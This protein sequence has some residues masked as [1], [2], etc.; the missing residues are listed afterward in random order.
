MTFR[1]PPSN[2][3]EPLSSGQSYD[4]AEPAAVD[5]A[6]IAASSRPA[7]RH[8][9]LTLQ[10]LAAQTDYRVTNYRVTDYKV[11]EALCGIAALRLRNSNV[12]PVYTHFEDE[13][14]R[15]LQTI[16]NCCFVR[17]SI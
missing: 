13:S 17:L 5:L 4:V 11:T 14:H 9:G 8:R 7:A 12:P 10:V 6:Q 1:S 3:H 16:M 2:A 15:D